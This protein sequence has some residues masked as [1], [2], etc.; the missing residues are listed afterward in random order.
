MCYAIFAILIVM[1]F[2][3]SDIIIQEHALTM[4]FN[5]SEWM[6]V[7][8]GWE[9]VQVIWPLLILAAVV[10]SAFTFMLPKLFSALRK[11]RSERT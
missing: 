2:L 5:D 6:T 10:G 11:A 7:A 4:R 9:M 1:L 3:Y 8:I